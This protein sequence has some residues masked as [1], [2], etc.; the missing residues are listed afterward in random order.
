M[1][2]KS[3]FNLRE[4]ERLRAFKKPSTKDHREV[5]VRETASSAISKYLT[6]FLRLYFV[7]ECRKI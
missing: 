2:E 4:E 3:V 7:G 6:C 5:K 1:A